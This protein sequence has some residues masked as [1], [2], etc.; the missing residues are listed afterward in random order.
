[1]LPHEGMINYL[2]FPASL[3]SLVWAGWVVPENSK[4]LILGLS[5]WEP[6]PILGA[7]Q[8]LIQSHFNRTKDTLSA[9]TLMNLQGFQETC[10][11]DGG[12]RHIRIR[13]VP[14]VLIC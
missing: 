6:A 5:F 11:R 2:L 9:L 8:E 12:Q 7:I 3:S 10:A 1:M 4:L 13:D 14:S